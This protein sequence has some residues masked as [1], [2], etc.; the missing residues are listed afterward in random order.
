MV[1]QKNRVLTVL[2]LNWGGIIRVQ[3]L[4]LGR[5]THALMG[6]GLPNNQFT[7]HD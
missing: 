6:V 1:V 5:P 2:G 7:L 3:P 4:S